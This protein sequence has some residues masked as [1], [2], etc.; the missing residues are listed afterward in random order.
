LFSKK[1]KNDGEID[2]MG[3]SVALEQDVVTIPGS[4]LYHPATSGT[5]VALSVKVKAYPKL[6]LGGSGVIY[7]A[8]CTFTFAG[9]GPAPANSPVNRQET[10]TLTAKQTKLQKRVLVQGDAMQSSYGNQLKIVT[11]SKVKT[12]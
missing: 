6:K 3:K 9:V 12:T 5:W 10:V 7:E 8:E 11:T 1:F 2:R 4:M